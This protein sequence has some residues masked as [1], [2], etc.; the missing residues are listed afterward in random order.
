MLHYID[1]TK[2]LEDN[3]TSLHFQL[4]IAGDL[5]HNC[6]SQF[7]KFS[8]THCHKTATDQKAV[9]QKLQENL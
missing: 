8:T 6:T 4:K 5:N 1:R 9:L 3:T 2:L 7:S